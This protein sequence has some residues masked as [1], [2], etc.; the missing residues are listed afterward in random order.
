MRDI[1]NL[2]AK[3]YDI[4]LFREM[5]F[6]EDNKILELICSNSCSRFDIRRIIL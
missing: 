6:E 2:K 1:T 3:S 4:S 5:S